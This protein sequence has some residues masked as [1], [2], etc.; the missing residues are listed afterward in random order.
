MALSGSV[1]LDP[2][3][4]S[5]LIIRTPGLSKDGSVLTTGAVSGPIAAAITLRLSSKESLEPL[6]VHRVKSINAT[7]H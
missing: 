2:S 1:L 4:D 3:S 7:K 5:A 6:T